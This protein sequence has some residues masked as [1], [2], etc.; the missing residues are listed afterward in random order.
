MVWKHIDAVIEHEFT[1]LRESKSRPEVAYKVTLLDKLYG[2]NRYSAWEIAES[3]I[4]AKIHEKLDE[5]PVELVKQIA[6]LAIK[7]RNGKKTRLGP[8]FA[9]KYCHFHRPDRFAIYDTYARNAI[10]DLQGR[11][12][13]DYQD[14][15]AVWTS[16]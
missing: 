13:H 12:P 10:A 16:W 8:V 6:G 15:K 3:L 11:K 4:E 5:N 2:C 7:H 14:Y 1:R 9:S